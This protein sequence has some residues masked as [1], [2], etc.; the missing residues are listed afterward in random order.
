MKTASGSERSQ[1]IL[2]EITA[3]YLVDEKR[4]ALAEFLARLE[5]AHGDDVRRVILYGSYARGDA[6]AESDVDVLVVAGGD[7]ETVRRIYHWCVHNQPSWVSPLV[8]SE[9][10]YQDDQR[11]QLPFYVNV[12]RDGIELWNPKAQQIEE[13]QIL[14][15]FPEGESRMIDYETLEAIRVYLQY[16]KDELDEAHILAQADHPS[17]AIGKL[18]YAAFDLTTAA[19]YTINIVR[20]KHK[21][22]KDAVNQFLVKPGLLEKEY[23][24]IYED[25]MEGR[26]N[27]D[28]R[29]SK[30]LKG[31]KIL[32][33]DELRQL[34]REGERYIERLKQFLIERGVDKSDFE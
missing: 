30:K 33:D 17:G 15:H 25:L 11:L 10:D 14:L 21:G 8:L 23:G 29:P 7:I 19:L 3:P 16:M 18:Y 28:Y 5:A 34:Y 13:Q 27:V 26:L 1:R 12:R 20:G 4:E 31:E 22:V 24:K 32:S 6:D 2:R 9:E